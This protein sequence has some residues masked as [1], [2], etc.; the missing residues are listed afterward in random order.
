MRQSALMGHST[1]HL[2]HALM[3]RYGTLLIN[4]AARAGVDVSESV[5]GSRWKSITRLELNSI[6]LSGILSVAKCGNL[7]LWPMRYL[8]IYR[9]PFRT[10]ENVD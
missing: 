1:R 4:Y 2:F 3:K 10:A 9:V 8:K 7:A 5:G 6:N